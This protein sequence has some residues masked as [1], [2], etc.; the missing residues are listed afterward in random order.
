MPGEFDAIE[1]GYLYHSIITRTEEIGQRIISPDS[2]NLFVKMGI[3]HN[4][5]PFHQHITTHAGMN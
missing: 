1:I 3:C 4:E 5:S 2:G